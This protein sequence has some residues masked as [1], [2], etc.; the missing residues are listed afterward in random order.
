V[1]SNQNATADDCTGC[2]VALSSQL[3]V[4][5]TCSTCGSECKAPRSLAHTPARRSIARPVARTAAVYVSPLPD[6][7]D[8]LPVP[9]RG[10]V[11]CERAARHP[12]QMPLLA[13]LQD[14]SR[15]AEWDVASAPK[16]AALNRDG[17]TRPPSTDRPDWVNANHNKLDHGKHLRDK[18]NALIRV[19][20]E[21]WKVL[22]WLVPRSKVLQDS[23]VGAKSATMRDLYRIVA[24]QFAGETK[25][26]KWHPAPPVLSMFKSEREYET[27][28]RDHDRRIRDGKLAVDAEGKRLVDAVIVAWFGVER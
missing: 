1:V 27:A 24:R 12:P 5:V 22:D 2:R 15:I 4:W 8:A 23:S 18:L 21:A 28:R 6:R 17:G 11:E 14:A 3:G 9:P 26:R 7:D 16:S 20:Y 13:L 10:C 19:D 25:W